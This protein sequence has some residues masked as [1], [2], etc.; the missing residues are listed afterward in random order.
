MKETIRQ[1]LCDVDGHGSMSRVL[2]VPLTAAVIYALIHIV[3]ATH[4]VTVEQAVA[5]C[6]VCGVLYFGN[7]PKAL[8]ALWKGITPPPDPPEPPKPP[9]A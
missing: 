2:T 6:M 4:S 1:A 7:Q 8:M 3:R 9:A 5:L